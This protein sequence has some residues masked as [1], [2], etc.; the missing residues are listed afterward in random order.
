MPL[1]EAMR[2]QLPIL[3]HPAAAVP[4]TVGK[5]ACLVNKRNWVELVES[6]HK[7]IVDGDYRDNLKMRGLQQS[8]ELSLKTSQSILRRVLQKHGLFGQ[9]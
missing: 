6:L 5:G 9:L 7:V 1:V 2:F 8:D 3:A 4:E